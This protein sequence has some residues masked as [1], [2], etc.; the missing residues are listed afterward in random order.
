M[1]WKTTQRMARVEKVRKN[2]FYSPSKKNTHKETKV[3][4]WIRLWLCACET[5]TFSQTFRVH[6]HL[7]HCYSLRW[8]FFLLFMIFSSFLCSTFPHLSTTFLKNS[9]LSAKFQQNFHFFWSKNFQ[10]FFT[11]TKKIFFF[12]YFKKNLCSVNFSIDSLNVTFKWK[13][14][15]SKNSNLCPKDVFCFVNFS[16]QKNW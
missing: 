6:F 8:I 7:F 1:R 2:S 13:S 3:Y 15:A 10:L 4:V 11:V 14:F 16:L 12:V 9:S 5:Q